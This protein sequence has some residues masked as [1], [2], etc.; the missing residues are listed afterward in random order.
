M[1]PLAVTL[2]A[3]FAFSIDRAERLA[4]HTERA[5]AFY[6]LD[7][8]DSAAVIAHE[9]RYERFARNKR[10]G[11]IGFG[12]LLFGPY[13]SGYRKDCRQAPRG[14]EFAG[15]LWS[16]KALRESIDLCG[17]SYLRGVGHYRGSGCRATFNARQTA[18]LSRMIRARM[19]APSLEP[20]KMPKLRIR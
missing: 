20:M 5:A 17:G 10:T 15:F 16:A 2:I 19:A 1:S 8:A 9:S 4:A 3:L 14:C 6:E 11:A 13:I 7:V 12:Q 18:K